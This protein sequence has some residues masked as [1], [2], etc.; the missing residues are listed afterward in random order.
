M[1]E[2]KII[3]VKTDN[4]PSKSEKSKA[5]CYDCNEELIYVNQYKR[6]LNGISH[7]VSEYYRH[8]SENSN[9]CNESITHKA[10]KH[11]IISKSEKFN[12]YFICI[13]C[14]GKHNILI[15]KTNL[16]EEQVWKK[17]R[18]DIGAQ[19]NLGNISS[20][21][22]ICYSHPISDEKAK[23][24]TNSN[25]AWVEVSANDI[26]MSETGE[27]NVLRCATNICYTCQDNIR[28][29]REKELDQNLEEYRKTEE[30]RINDKNKLIKDTEELWYRTHQEI[31]FK[32]CED[33]SK[34]GICENCEKMIKEDTVS[35]C[36][37]LL[38]QNYV[39]DKTINHLRG[40]VC[41][42]AEEEFWN[43]T[44]NKTQKEIDR[45]W[46]ILNQ[47]VLYVVR[48]K[49]KELSLDKDLAE[50]Q[51][52]EI[53]EDNTIIS[54]GKHKG[55]PLSLIAERD[56]SY[57]VRVAG[58]YTGQS[59]NNKPVRRDKGDFLS[60]YVSKELEQAALQEIKGR[61][62]ECSEY[63]DNDEPSWKT[64]CSKCYRCLCR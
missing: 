62:Y 48:V 34:N 56:W 33:C 38:K 13:Q 64:W 60:K 57:L 18:L 53:L 54:F 43:Y 2:T 51:A 10:A 25:I 22:E 5:K 28:Q 9:C 1:K 19:D 32:F 21:I 44:P 63:F 47:E 61:C 4:G 52:K 24:L 29:T 16:K 37:E 6:V 42:K 36:R 7:D 59:L 27:I 39:V 49:A 31:N 20:A 15:D 58:F 55:S 45:K 46:A 23:D 14:C 26:L 8:K 12:Y 50:R 11:A 41:R 3:W 35:K 17:Y 40:E 30:S